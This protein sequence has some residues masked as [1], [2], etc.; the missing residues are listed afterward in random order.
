MRTR[1]TVVVALAVLVAFAGVGGGAPTDAPSTERPTPI[2]S[3]TTI[4]DPGIYQ[5]TGDVGN[6]SDAETRGCITIRSGNVTL[7]GNGHTVAGTYDSIFVGTA[8]PYRDT[9]EYLPNVTVRD[10]VVTS[11]VELYRTP[12]ATVRNITGRN[13]FVQIIEGDGSVVVNNTLSGTMRRSA[14]LGVSWSNGSVIANNTVVNRPGGDQYSVERGSIRV[15]TSNNVTVRGNVARSIATGLDVYNVTNGTFVNN[16]VTGTEGRGVS[17]SWRSQDN[18]FEDTDVSDSAVGI[19]VFGSAGT[20]FR[21]VTA[22]NTTDAVLDARNTDTVRLRGARTGPNTTVSV[23]GRN[24]VVRSV[25]SPPPVASD[26]VAVGGFVEVIQYR[27]AELSLDVGY[28]EAAVDVAG[29]N[30]SDL[31][32]YRYPAEEKPSHVYALMGPRTDTPTADGWEPV[33]GPHE[34]NTTANRVSTDVTEF[35]F[36]EPDVP[37]DPTRID[38]GETVN[39]T[40]SSDESDWYAFEADA[41][42]AILPT[43]NLVGPLENRAV[44]FAIVG[45]GGTTIGAYPADGMHGND[46]EAGTEWP[47]VGRQATG[48]ATAEEDG[49][50][51]VRVF[52]GSTNAEFTPG[53]YDLTVETRELDPFDPNQRPET[54]TRLTPNATVNG[55]SAA[56]DPDWFSFEAE[57]GDRL[58]V[59]GRAEYP[60]DLW[61]LGP[62]GTPLGHISSYGRNGTVTVTAPQTG[63]YYVQARQ[64]GGNGEL[65]AVGSYDVTVRTSADGGGSGG[66]DVDT[67]GDGLTDS[68]EAEYA[69]DPASTDT[70]GDGWSDRSEVNRGCDPLD[71]NSHP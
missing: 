36:E 44:Q 29:L 64:D 69:T 46:Y 67:D 52:P 31:R 42:E 63:R 30:E 22:T 11:D 12:G 24:V 33:S 8:V 58:T 1:S 55:T 68:E 9:A 18:V 51:Y 3:C 37:S 49:T 40:L 53:A 13:S 45:P 61:L 27:G 57:A 16:T 70:D 56:Y 54:A 6:G 65:L 17:V 23:T 14:S 60:V 2:D 50:Y 59:T 66:G 47:A 39:G 15:G 25:E 41:G 26:L 32:L 7:D 10:V 5:L 38:V 71:P 34:V 19:A 35:D 4:T 48:A 62:D 21:N 43:L 20:T 28:D